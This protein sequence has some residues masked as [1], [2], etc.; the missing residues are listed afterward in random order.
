MREIGEKIKKLRL[1]AG[2]SQ[3][4]VE[5]RTGVDRS[6]LST[7]ESGYVAP[8]EKQ[9]RQLIRIL[10]AAV[11]DRVKVVSKVAAEVERMKVPV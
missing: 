11:K 10:S 3:W 4:E 9:V 2:L 8:S 1:A 6:T 7:I 5:K